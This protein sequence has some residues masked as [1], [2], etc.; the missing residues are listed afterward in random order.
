MQGAAG[1]RGR[2]AAQLRGGH[3]A[4]TI[5]T[6]EEEPSKQER[7]ERRRQKSVERKIEDWGGCE[8]GRP[9]GWVEAGKVIGRFQ[10]TR[11]RG[12]GGGGCWMP[13]EIP[14][15]GC[16][17]GE[18]HHPNLEEEKPVTYIDFH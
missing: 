14:S 12:G 8:L 7:Q 16:G 1:D 4:S 17:R 10:E 13:R 9:K 3:Q 15:S 6:R 5:S 18:F 2:G 11:C